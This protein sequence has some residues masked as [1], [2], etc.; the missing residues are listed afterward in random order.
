MRVCRA[1]T[2]GGQDGA[3]DGSTAK[4]ALRVAHPCVVIPLVE[5]HEELSLYPCNVA[6]AAIVDRPKLP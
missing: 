2:R 6:R 4:P 1:E 5:T 3:V